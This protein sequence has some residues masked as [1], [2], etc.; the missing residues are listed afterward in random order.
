V[1]PATDSREASDDLP[2]AGQ[3]RRTGHRRRNTL[4]AGALVVVVGGA[5]AAYLVNDGDDGSSGGASSVPTST[6][7]ITRGDVVD[8]ESVDGKL[9]YSDSRTIA[10]AGSVITWVPTEGSTITRGRTLLRLDNKPVVLMYGQLP[11]YRPLS[12]GVSDGSDV[13]EL[14]RNLKALGYGDD[15]TVDKEFTSA[16][17][18]A[19]EEWQDDHGLTEN[20]TIDAGQVV[21]QPGAVRVSGV[22][23][24]K[25]QRIGP[26]GP[27]LTVSDTQSIVHVDLDA[28][29]QGLAK[30]GATVTVQLPNGKEVKGR[31]T[32]VGTV[33]K[34][35][36]SQ[37][38]TTATIDVD[39][40]LQGRNTGKLDQAPVSVNLESARA[41]DVLS[42]PI[43]ALL[44][45]RE[46]G[47]GVEVVTGSI[48]RIV[49]V[50]TGTFGSGR[51]EVTGDGLAEGMKVGVPSS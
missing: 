24:P 4:L 51:V 34:S 2:V 30:K 31:I 48:S 15:L 3:G 49:P 7:P 50:K 5:T 1:R 27:A 47:F 18:D 45:L 39:I 26:G 38:D 37:D 28:G 6:A 12:D 25:G 9:T 41:K 43:E 42:V 33:A 13:L 21:F 35:S 29:K 16:T 22:K 40:A 20:G 46:G 8:S 32:D 36:G 23:A 19:V 14:E 44:G 10:T 11:L 17:A